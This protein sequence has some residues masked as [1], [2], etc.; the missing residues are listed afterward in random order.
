M[1]ELVALLFGDRVKLGGF[2]AV[3]GLILVLLLARSAARRLLAVP[4]ALTS[5]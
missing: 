2:I 3:P 5:A 4:D 1:L